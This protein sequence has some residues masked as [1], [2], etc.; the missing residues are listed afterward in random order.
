MNQKVSVQEKSMDLPG[1]FF[2]LIQP[3]RENIIVEDLLIK[4]SHGNFINQIYHKRSFSQ[5]QRSL[6]RFLV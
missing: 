5:E 2:E 3:S 1:L 6:Y 4:Q